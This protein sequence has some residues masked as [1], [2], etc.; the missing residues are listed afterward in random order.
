MHQRSPPNFTKRI[1]TLQ[2]KFEA[3]DVV[4]PSPSS[5]EVDVMFAILDSMPDLSSHAKKSS[6]VRALMKEIDQMEEH[7]DAAEI[8]KGDSESSE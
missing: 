7:I 6:A 3:L 1:Q 8:L 5:Y 4:R 2:D